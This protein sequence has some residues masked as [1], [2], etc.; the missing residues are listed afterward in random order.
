MSPLVETLAEHYDYVAEALS[1]GT[2]VPLLGAGANLCDPGREGWELGRNLPSGGELS[3]YLVQRYGYPGVD[4]NDLL[5]VSQYAEAKRGDGTLYDALHVVF[6]ATYGYTVVHEF[7]A[8]LPGRLAA[9]GRP[10]PHQLIVTTNYDDAL[11]QALTKAGEQFDLIWYS[12]VGRY[13]GKFLHKPPDGEVRPIKRPNEYRLSIEDRTVILKIHGA[14]SRAN[15][16]SD[17]Y[18]ISE[19]HYIRFLSNTNLNNLL[20]KTLLATLVDSHFLFLGYSLRDWNLRVVLHQIWTER[21]QSRDSWAIQRDVDEID[22]ALWDARN[23][24]LHNVALDVYVEELSKRLPALEGGHPAN[25]EDGGPA[26]HG[27]G[28]PAN[29]GSGRPAD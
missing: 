18:V 9:A 27:S 16:G 14:V 29:Q 8:G 23:V 22:S 4:T 21:E 6:T 17:S 25:L 13:A 28:H 10:S 7:L 12:A 19:D 11:E 24:R 15:R 20:P 3:Q 1:Y 2:V 26:D 5:R